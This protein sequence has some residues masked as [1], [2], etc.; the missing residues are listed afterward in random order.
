MSFA[1][2]LRTINEIGEGRKEK[3]NWKHTQILD[4][5]SRM[6]RTN[7]FFMLSNKMYTR[8]D[9]GCYWSWNEIMNFHRFPSFFFWMV[10]HVKFPNN[11]LL[12]ISTCDNIF[13]IIKEKKMYDSN[14][15][16]KKTRNQLK[17][18]SIGI[19][20]RK[21]ISFIR[22]MWNKKRKFIESNNLIIT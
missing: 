7:F 19:K 11:V 17:Y 18:P 8:H 6:N 9:S 12:P 10:S 5:L 21:R 15:W 2:N 4:T 1:R 14:G 16:I 3:K 20:R 13:R 22:L